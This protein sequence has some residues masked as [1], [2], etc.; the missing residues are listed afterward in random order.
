MFFTDIGLIS[1]I[2]ILYN[3]KFTH[4]QYPKR[5]RFFHLYLIGVL[6]ECQGKGYASKLM[7]P[8]LGKMTENSIPVYLE[9]ANTNNV[10]IY[11]KKGFKVYDSW[12]K[13]GLK[14]FYMKKE[15]AP[16]EK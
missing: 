8:I 7:N 12:F 5:K 13:S 3:E 9:T 2:R 16:I 10:K 1:I 14:L 6:P 11:E 4:Q 15:E